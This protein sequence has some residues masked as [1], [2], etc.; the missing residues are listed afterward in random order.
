[1]TSK[2]RRAYKRSCQGYID[3]HDYQ[4]YDDERI[5]CEDAVEILQSLSFPDGTPEETVKEQV[6]SSLREKGRRHYE[7]E[8]ELSVG[9]RWAIAVVEGNPQRHYNAYHPRRQQQS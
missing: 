1:M 5:G 4:A 8:E 7:N 6:V 2:A 9:V 3:R